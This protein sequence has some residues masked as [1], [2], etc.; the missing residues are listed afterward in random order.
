MEWNIYGKTYIYNYEG[1]LNGKEAVMR[2]SLDRV[3]V[4]RRGQRL[5][6]KPNTRR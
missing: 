2:Y 3:L 5:G 6:I 1:S 4:A